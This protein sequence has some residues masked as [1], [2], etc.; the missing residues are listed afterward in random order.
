MTYVSVRFFLKKL[1]MVLRSLRT[2][3]GL[4]KVEVEFI[5]KFFYFNDAQYLLVFLIVNL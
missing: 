1:K 4:S 5:K 3:L 2:L